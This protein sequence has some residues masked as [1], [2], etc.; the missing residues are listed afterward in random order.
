MPL[1]RNRSNR[2]PFASRATILGTFLLLAAF[3]LLGALLAGCASNAP[4]EQ[5]PDSMPAASD[6]PIET[7]ET[8]AASAAAPS[9]GDAPPS[10]GP[11]AIDDQYA[12]AKKPSE[13][14]TPRLDDGSRP[15]EADGPRVEDRSGVSITVQA[16]TRSEELADSMTATLVDEGYDVRHVASFDYPVALVVYRG[17]SLAADAFAIAEE[18]GIE[19]V[20]EAAPNK[21]NQF[22]SDIL[23]AVAPI[24]MYSRELLVW[25]AP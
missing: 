17:E 14:V 24:N 25:P 23:V 13:H 1:S 8:N 10:T 22:D 5:A 2:S 4:K 21:Y 19:W 7:P 9:D 3:C 6:Q 18:L 15:P 16:N 11:N 20:E 12:Q